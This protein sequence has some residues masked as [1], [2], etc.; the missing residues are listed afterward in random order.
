M[1]E[2]RKSP[3]EYRS[4]EQPVKT[5][6]IGSRCVVFTYYQGDINSVVDEHFS[7]ALRNTKDPQDLSTKNRSDDFLPKNSKLWRTLINVFIF[8]SNIV[9]AY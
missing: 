3:V 8:C 4:K 9:P 1:E 6:E 2:L 7:R 5:T